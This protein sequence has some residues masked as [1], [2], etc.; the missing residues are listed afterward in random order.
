MGNTGRTRDIKHTYKL[1]GCSEATDPV[2]TNTSLHGL[3]NG[4]TA[5][6]GMNVDKAS[7]LYDWFLEN[8]SRSIHSK[9]N[10]RQSYL[11][12]SKTDITIKDQHV[13]V[14]NAEYHCQ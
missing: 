6:E 3:V 13:Q 2:A 8:M 4:V 9:W 5:N 7:R 11:F 10:V 1:T 14:E 12:G